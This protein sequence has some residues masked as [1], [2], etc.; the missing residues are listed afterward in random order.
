MDIVLR[1]MRFCFCF[2]CLFAYSHVCFRCL[3]AHAHAAEAR[4]LR[5]LRAPAPTGAGALKVPLLLSLSARL[6]ARG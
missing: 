3:H 6:F 2:R 1:H 4:P 5:P